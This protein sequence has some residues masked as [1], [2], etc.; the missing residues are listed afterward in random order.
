MWRLLLERV[1]QYVRPV[2]GLVLAREG[3]VAGSVAGAERWR[4]S[5]GG[6]A[7]AACLSIRSWRR[8]WFSSRK[9]AFSCRKRASSA[10][11]RVLVG[12][13][14]CACEEEAGANERIPAAKRTAQTM[15]GNRPRSFITCTR[16]ALH[17]KSTIQKQ[18]PGEV[19]RC[20]T[21]YCLETA[22]ATL[23]ATA[24]Q[25][26]RLMLIAIS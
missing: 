14:D 7:G 17:V 9:A 2:L 5:A 19:L 16:Y 18:C 3:T 15:E 22:H 26:K 11:E 23:Q 8:R 21:G 24:W 20:V 1:S 25:T 13:A 4:G 6:A 12:A 10:D